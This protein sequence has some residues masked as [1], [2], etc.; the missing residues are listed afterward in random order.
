M[1]TEPR[2][3]RRLQHIVLM[4]FPTELTATEDVELRGIVASLI[5]PIDALL[6]CRFDSDLTGSRTQ[7]Y[8]YLLYTE[9][10][11]TEALAEYVAHPAHQ[12]LVSWVDARRC[13]R[14]A[15]DYYIDDPVKVYGSPASLSVKKPSVDPH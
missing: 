15:F 6:T 1:T 13:Q 3:S 4:R 12:E 10:R 9:V 11:D 2:V 14:L 7:G 8:Q 5:D